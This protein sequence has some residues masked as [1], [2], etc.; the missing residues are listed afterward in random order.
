MPLIMVG[1]IG[2]EAKQPFAYPLRDIV[3]EFL[4]TAKD[5][6]KEQARKK[7]LQFPNRII[8]SSVEHFDFT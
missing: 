2:K 3:E 8:P 1:D 6:S 5:S 4:I 7:S